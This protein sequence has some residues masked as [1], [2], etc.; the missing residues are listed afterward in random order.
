MTRLRLSFAALLCL[1]STSAWADLRTY[2][3]D[4]QYRN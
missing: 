4:F 3:V 2:D 1:I